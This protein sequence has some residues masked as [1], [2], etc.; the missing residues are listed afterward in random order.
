M[1]GE[2]VLVAWVLGTV[3]VA[4]LLKRRQSREVVADE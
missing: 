2:L 3:A 1:M 4:G